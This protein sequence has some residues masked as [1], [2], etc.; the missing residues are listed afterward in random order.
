[1]KRIWNV[2]FPIPQLTETA[3]EMI[4]TFWEQIFTLKLAMCTLRLNILS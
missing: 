4:F 3:S 2:K 1:M